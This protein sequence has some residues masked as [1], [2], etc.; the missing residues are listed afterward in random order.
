MIQKKDPRICFVCESTQIERIV[1][2]AEH[3]LYLVD[4]KNCDSYSISDSA[5]SDLQ[6][7]RESKPEYLPLLSHKIYR[8]QHQDSHPFVSA[9]WLRKVFD[10][11]LD[12]P[13]AFEQVENLIIHL[14]KVLGAGDTMRLDRSTCQAAVGAKNVA[15]LGW[16]FTQAKNRGWVQGTTKQTDTGDVVIASGALTLD[17]WEWYNEIGRHKRSRIA[18]MAM[19]YGD[20]LLTSVVNDYLRPAVRQTGFE[21]KLLTD[22]PEAGLIDNRLRVEIRRS[23]FVIA[24][25]THHNNGAYWEAG[26]GEGL[27]LP[28]I[29]TCRQSV[30]AEQGE[31]K[32]HFDTRNNLIVPWD[33][34]S[35]KQ[36]AKELKATIRNTLPEEAILEDSE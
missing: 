28:V 7:W 36:A 22:D 13:S 26:F 2:N 10:G 31:K 15:S 16:V 33:E 14:A 8:R 4:C 23:R 24:D 21:L 11:P 6:H 3:G 34:A 30:L 9:D 20:D 17:G 5:V 1:R 29:Y 27:G 25:L 19:Q 12:F 32:V 18:F 35:P